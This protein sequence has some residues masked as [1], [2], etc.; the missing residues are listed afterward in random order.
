MTTL[1]PV[2]LQIDDGVAQ[3][4]LNRPEAGNSLTVP[5]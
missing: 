2:H 5:L 1:D 4:T 3:I